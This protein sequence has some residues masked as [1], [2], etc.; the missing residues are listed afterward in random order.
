LAAFPCVT[1][2]APAPGS[3]ILVRA[4]AAFPADDAK[5]VAAAGKSVVNGDSVPHEGKASRKFPIIVTAMTQGSPDIPRRSSGTSR[6]RRAFPKINQPP[7]KKKVGWA[8][9]QFRPQKPHPDSRH[10]PRPGGA[11]NHRNLSR[12]H[13]PFKMRRASA[14]SK[15]SSDAAFLPN[16]FDIRSRIEVLRGSPGPTLVSAQALSEAAKRPKTVRLQKN[17]QLQPS[18]TKSSNLR[19]LRSV[20]HS[21]PPG[22]S[23]TRRS[24][25]SGRRSC[26]HFIASTLEVRASRFWYRR[27]AGY[28]RSHRCR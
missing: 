22:P 15:I 10:R 1:P 21:S 13:A 26:A 18:L 4:R 8:I 17:Y 27:R 2:L 12:E 19:P 7:H 16:S 6:E 20:L 11:G 9:R 23:P 3:A 24:G 28:I 5:T 14:P 25:R